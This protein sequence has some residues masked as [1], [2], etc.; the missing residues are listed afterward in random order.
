MDIGNVRGS[1][2]TCWSMGTTAHY[3]FRY[4]RGFTLIELLAGTAIIAVLIGLL[5]P[6]LCRARESARH[7]QNVAECSGPG[8][9]VG[10]QNRGG[11]HQQPGEARR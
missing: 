9:P 7:P 6:T 11:I 4:A 2:L 8:L 3:R 5:L 1:P 10:I